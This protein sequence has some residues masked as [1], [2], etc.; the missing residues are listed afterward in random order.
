MTATADGGSTSEFSENLSLIQVPLIIVAYSPVNLMVFDPAGDSIGKDPFGLIG[1]SITD[2]TYDEVLNDSINIR[3]PL[4]G[5]YMIIVIPENDA[6]PEAVYS[7]GIRI[8]GSTQCIL[9][10]EADVPSSDEPDTVVYV[11]EEGYHYENGDASGDKIINLIDI[12][13]LIDCLYG[14]GEVT[15][16]DPYLSG[17]ANCDRILNLLDILYLIAYRY[18]TPPGPP[19]CPLGE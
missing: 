13:L 6:P 15:C 7:I 19:P 12:L 18:N 8:D 10:E 3:Y 1:Q 2:A 9:V 16:P 17:D 4:E 5:E 14:T 11:V